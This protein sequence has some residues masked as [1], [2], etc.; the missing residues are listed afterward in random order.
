VSDPLGGLAAPRP[1]VTCADPG[2]RVDDSRQSTGPDRIA[3]SEWTANADGF[4]DPNLSAEA[5]GFDDPG[6]ATEAARAVDAEGVG[7]DGW[8]SDFWGGVWPLGDPAASTVPALLSVEPDRPV[9][10]RLDLAS[11]APGPALARELASV[12]PSEV[13]AAGL[14]D[15]IVGCE[16]PPASHWL[17]RQ[18]AV[19]QS[20][21]PAYSVKSA[22]RF[23]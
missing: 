3:R 18:D 23:A 7:N 2:S 6:W 12:R 10:L 8:A 19:G 14:V 16:G 1:D 5:A 17:R 15:L 11:V 4:D 9:D 13:S 20:R 21:L 22:S